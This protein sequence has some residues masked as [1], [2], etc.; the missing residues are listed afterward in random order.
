[1]A[2][3]SLTFL[4][5]G[6]VVDAVE[7]QVMFYS[8]QVAIVHWLV[9]AVDREASLMTD[10]E[11]D[12]TY[13]PPHTVRLQ[14]ADLAAFDVHVGDVLNFEADL[15]WAIEF[16]GATAAPKRV[17]QNLT[18]QMIAKSRSFSERELGVGHYQFDLLGERF[19][20]G[21]LNFDEWLAGQRGLT[22]APSLLK[23][24]Q[25][26]QNYEQQRVKLEAA[27]EDRVMVVEDEFWNMDVTP[28][29]MPREV[30]GTVDNSSKHIELRRISA[31]D[32][33][34]RWQ[35][36]LEEA[37]QWQVDHPGGVSAAT[38]EQMK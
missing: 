34:R 11:V 15:D 35:T 30:L 37:Q 25:L 33:A 12:E 20:Q 21:R 9:V 16:T 23:L 2:K 8:G 17:L 22:A 10:P 6:Q 7:E 38:R 36:L 3:H 13:P 5:Q 24:Q 1:M 26:L 32:T 4:I 28:G 31:Q 18:A 27:Q 29:L 19:A 14:A